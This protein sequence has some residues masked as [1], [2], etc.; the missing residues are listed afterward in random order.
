MVDISVKKDTV[1]ATT[2]A[3]HTTMNC[4]VCI[5]D[6]CVLLALSVLGPT[7]DIRD[8]EKTT[9]DYEFYRPSPH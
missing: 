4:G 5:N 6:S 1:V 2:S 3:A 9:T 7:L 8:I